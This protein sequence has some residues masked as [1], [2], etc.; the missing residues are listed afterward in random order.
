M[1]L[2][3]CMPRTYAWITDAAL[4]RVY[5]LVNGPLCTSLSHS[6]RPAGVARLS[7]ISSADLGGA[8]AICCIQT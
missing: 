2:R 6:L 1:R 7:N 8:F 5:R 4:L 3:V